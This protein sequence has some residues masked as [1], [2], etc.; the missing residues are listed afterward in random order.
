MRRLLHI[1]I[2][3]LLALSTVAA[4]LVLTLTLVEAIGSAASRQVE[5]DIGQSLAELAFQTTDKLDRGMYERYREVQL[6]AERFEITEKG[7]PAAAKRAVLESM[8]ETYPDYAWIGLTDTSGK[9][10]VAT[11]GMLEG[12][13][14][15]Q[16]PWYA[17]AY[18]E[19]HLTDV[20]EA[21]LLAKLLPSPAGEP[22]RFFDI[23]FPYRN[24]EGD[25][26][27][28]LGTHLSWQWAKDIEDSVL[29]PLARRA[30]VETL[31]VSRHG[32]V[33]LGPARYKD[34]DLALGS[35][36]ASRAKRNGY[37]IES[38]PDGKRYL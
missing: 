32:R 37:V 19:E 21:V 9:V 1:G 28:I 26:E 7:I 10:L 14:V 36:N 3:P 6:I 20:H 5:A 33:L 23:A 38:W 30:S 15:S 12:A 31:I 17:A 35:L 34:T 25:I 29:R 27:G 22:K 8:Q 24:K 11:K 18:R 13:D 2:A 4:T 16:R